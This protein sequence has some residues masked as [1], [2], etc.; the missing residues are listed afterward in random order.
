LNLY[1][2]NFAY[3]RNLRE[4]YMIDVSIALKAKVFFAPVDTFNLQWL[5]K[6]YLH[7]ISLS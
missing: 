4:I 2:F 1:C 6:V 7:S 5:L 3:I